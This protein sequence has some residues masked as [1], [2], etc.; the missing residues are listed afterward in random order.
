M[1]IQQ[2]KQKD[3][4]KR[5]KIWNCLLLKKGEIHFQPTPSLN[6]QSYSCCTSCASIMWETEWGY[7]FMHISNKQFFIL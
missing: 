5:S 7:G 4:D 1:Q 6:H 3:K 2:S